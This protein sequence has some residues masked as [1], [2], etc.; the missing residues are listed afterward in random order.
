VWSRT[1]L[2]FVGILVKRRDKQRIN[3][4][5]WA[6]KVCIETPLTAPTA[7]LVFSVLQG[8]WDSGYQTMG[9]VIVTQCTRHYLL[10][11]SQASDRIVVTYPGDRRS[12]KVLNPWSNE[13]WQKRSRSLPVVSS[14][15]VFSK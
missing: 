3:L 15:L 10:M 14:A 11:T 5:C 2:H 1:S 13:L 6:G 7:Q 8:E 4:D 9:V 12:K